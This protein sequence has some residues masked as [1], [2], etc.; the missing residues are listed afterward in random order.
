MYKYMS[1]LDICV[2]TGWKLIPFF[3][4]WKISYKVC[5]KEK[6]SQQGWDS[7]TNNL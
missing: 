2:C 7:H 5:F 3:P 1:N 4:K 6:E